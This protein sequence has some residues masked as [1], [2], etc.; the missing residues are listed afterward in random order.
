MSYFSFPDHSGDENAFITDS[1]IN[2]SPFTK[3]MNSKLS[4]YLFLGKFNL[5]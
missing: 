4:Y 1:N 2:S 5:K 3:S